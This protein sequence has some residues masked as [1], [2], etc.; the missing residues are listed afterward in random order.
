M[1]YLKPVYHNSIGTTY[2]ITSDLEENNFQKIQLQLAELAILL[3]IQELKHLLKIIDTSRKGC[4]CKGCGK[5]YCFKL[6]KC[7]TTFAQIHFKTTAKNVNGLEELIQG[8]L[9]ELAME[10][11]L[12]ANEI[13]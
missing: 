8:T 9:F 2:I 6:I 3:S 5:K 4:E 10:D 1:H 11:L 7:D 12:T 13:D